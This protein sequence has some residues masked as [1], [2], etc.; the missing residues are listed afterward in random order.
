MPVCSRCTAPIRH[1]PARERR[2]LSGRPSCT[3]VVAHRSRR[4]RRS[5]APA[6]A[7]V[8]RGLRSAVERAS[9]LLRSGALNSLAD[10]T[11]WR[12]WA[13]APRQR[14]G[15][16]AARCSARCAHEKTTGWVP[17]I[18]PPDSPWQRTTARAAVEESPSHAPD[19]GTIH[20]A[21]PPESGPGSRQARRDL[22]RVVGLKHVNHGLCCG[23][24]RRLP[25]PARTTPGY[26]LLLHKTR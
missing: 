24:V 6:V 9:R 19:D 17:D 12:C 23:V 1:Q 15:G 3:L 8:V 18:A 20:A 10:V 5:T 22:G 4:P 2:G 11:D 13:R 21:A 25:G 16:F 7:G 14:S 26:N